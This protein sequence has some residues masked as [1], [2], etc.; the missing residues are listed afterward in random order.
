MARTSNFELK[1]AKQSIALLYEISRAV[2]SNR[3]LEEILSLVVNLTAELMHSKICSLMLLEGEKQELVIKA[4]QSLSEIYRT[5]PPI[6]VGESVSGRAM[7]YQRPITV[8]D[9]TL[10]KD[11]KYPEIARAEGLKSLVSVPMMVKDRAIGVLNCYTTEERE[12]THDEIQILSGVANQAA[13]AIENT[14]LLAEKIVAVEAVETRKKV[15]HAKSILM[16]R[17]QINEKDAYRMIQKQSMDKRRSLKEV[18]EAII[19]S[20][21]IAIIN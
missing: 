14:K 17:H 10:D 21:D 16:K 11:Y 5:K 3:Y 19:V 15:E 20:E 7:L 2:V 13:L 8:L 4:T 6:K 1:R 9:V 18:A 12:F